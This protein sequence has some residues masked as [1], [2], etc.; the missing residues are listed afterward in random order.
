MRAYEYQALDADGK[1]I[2]GLIEGDSERHARAQLRRQGL[3]PLRLKTADAKTKESDFLKRLLASKPKIS[4]LCLITRQLALL[5]QSG[6]P[7]DETLQ[8]TVKQCRHTGLKNVLADVRGDVL[9]GM[10]L[11]K[12]LNSHPSVFNNLYR[13]LVTA[14]E[15]SGHLGGVLERL[16]DYTETRYQSQQKLKS[17]MTYPIILIVV[18][19]LVVAL[20]MSFVVP[21]LVSIFD[22]TR[23]ELPGLTQGLIASSDFLSAYWLHCSLLI[24]AAA[25]LF[26]HLLRDPERRL[27][28]HR[29]LLA[30]PFIGDTIRGMETARFASTLSILSQSGV[31]LLEGLRIS[32]EVFNNMV[33]RDIAE[34][35]A[36]DVSEGASFHR[37]MADSGEFPP[38]MV[39][40]VASGETSGN[41]EHMLDRSALNQERELQLRLDT[42]MSTVQPL[43]V[44]IMAGLVLTI[45]LAI[46][47]PM[48][49]LNN[50]VQ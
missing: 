36:E 13:A 42:L 48:F 32:R 35:I 25:A 24:A 31:P 17:A 28:F 38:M 6:M 8:A 23:A 39:Q 34:S 9:E 33:L 2:R 21:R 46:M 22:N 47:M 5:L 18:A 11:A 16:A 12:A 20:L 49:E 1:N 14:G 10:S 3:R 45:V 41:L 15:K 4:D 43:M 29:I 7:L 37:S 26:R 44:L 30:T 19:I 27:K 50:L 40:M